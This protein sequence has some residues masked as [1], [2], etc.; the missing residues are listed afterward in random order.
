M[1]M[2]RIAPVVLIA[3]VGVGRISSAQE[4]IASVDLVI[5]PGT[6]LRVVLDERLTVKRAGQS[7]NGTLAEPIYVYDRIVLPAGV[8]VL[9]HVARFQQAPRVDRMRAILGGSFSTLRRVI[10]EFD[11]VVMEDG[12]EVP[13][14]TIVTGTPA[15]MRR[16]VAG[17]GRTPDAPEPDGVIDAAKARAR[18]GIQQARD[19]IK[20]R[21][22]DAIAAIREP[23]KLDRL[24]E[25]AMNRLPYHPQFVGK[26]TVYNAQLIGAVPIGVV[27]PAAV[28]PGAIPAP[29]S[30]LQ[31]RLI[32][33]L[34]STK[35][36]RGTPV[37]AVI[38]RP[39]FSADHQLVLAE[40]TFLQGEV[41]F[42]KNARHFRRNGQLRFL[43]ESVRPPSQQ[44]RP[45]LASLRSVET[46]SG[47][48]VA[49]DD[50]GGASVTNPKTRFIAPTL[51]ILAMSRTL[52]AG[53]PRVD[54]DADDTVSGAATSG[55]LGSGG[56]GGFIGFGL[57]GTAL[58]MISHPA[59][60]AFGALG[61][62]RSVYSSVIAKGQEVI[63]SA[64]TPI[65]VQLAATPSPAKQ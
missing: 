63:F 57:I 1:R 50:E 6:P 53:A 61:V 62:A 59:A 64:D 17:A 42:T 47:D 5:R 37:D 24:K 31:A 36:P 25:A 41:T 14:R 8:R 2:N 65:E 26:G 45:M 18:A 16:E 35:T 38:T 4:Q 40:G 12:R 32:T 11:T 9:G 27:T 51:A 15:R 19:D 49:L 21:K 52:D 33:A 3:A 56:V 22:D 39:V 34:D 58:S 46:S 13:I 55:H 28:S 20:Q 60:L 7:V 48:H 43:F 54:G 10:V 29:R 44:P 23:G 30:V